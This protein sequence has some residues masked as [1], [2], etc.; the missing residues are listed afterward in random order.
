MRRTITYAVTIL[1][2][3]VFSLAAAPSAFASPK[4]HPSSDAPW[5]IGALVL[6]VLAVGALFAWLRKGN[7]R[8]DPQRPFRS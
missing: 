8:R 1:G 5:F 4:N 7:D 2:L 3:A 6:V